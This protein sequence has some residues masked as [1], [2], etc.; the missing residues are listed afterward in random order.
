M[1]AVRICTGKFSNNLLRTEISIFIMLVMLITF[2]ICM[3]QLVH[4]L[5]RKN[6][7]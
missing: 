3:G 4:I 5:F 7:G 2:F 1:M 6:L